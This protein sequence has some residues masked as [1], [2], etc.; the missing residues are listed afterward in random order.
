[1]L[2][3]ILL[4]WLSYFCAYIGRANY[5]ACIVDIVSTTGAT[6]AQAGLV[7]SFFYI[8]YGFGQIVN[9]ILSRKANSIKMIGG[10]LFASA[11]I[12]LL[13]PSVNNIDIMKYLWFVN[14][15]VQSALWPNIIKIYSDILIKSVISKAVVAI[16]TVGAS[17]TAAV[18][19][20]TYVFIKY[21]NWKGTFFFGAII[22]FL[23]AV[24]WMLG[25][26]YIN[27]HRSPIVSSLDSTDISADMKTANDNGNA[28]S[29]GNGNNNDIVNGI[30]IGWK[31]MFKL[32]AISGV[33]F[34]F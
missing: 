3:I 30:D 29:N 26:K 24:V 21:F 11:I 28:I 1:M 15:L 23:M 9:G 34:A 4:C 7:S 5:N 6:N 17:G 27:N 16:H 20:I 31:E 32:L 13:M 2:Y 14:G 33:L 22:L 12:N 25:M 8:S 18:Y 19:G 10:A